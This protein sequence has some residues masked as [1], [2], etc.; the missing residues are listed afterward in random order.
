MKKKLIVTGIVLAM[1]TAGLLYVNTM[2]TNKLF[3]VNSPVVD[4]TLSTTVW[5]YDVERPKTNPLQTTIEAEEAPELVVE[6][7][8][9]SE[10]EPQV[11]PESEPETPVVESEPEPE[12]PVVVSSQPRCNFQNRSVEYKITWSDG[13][14]TYSNVD[15]TGENMHTVCM[16]PN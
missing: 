16:F 5:D 8:P 6:S 11:S 15:P 12:T 13:S 3:N 2:S 7:T 1:S 14:V 4:R 9:A 10:P